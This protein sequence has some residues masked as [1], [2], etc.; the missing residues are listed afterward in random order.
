MKKRVG[1]IILLCILFFTTSVYASSNNTQFPKSSDFKGAV[2]DEVGVLNEE[3][4]E[5]INNT[6]SSLKS[7]TGGQIAVVILNSLNG[8]DAVSYSVG[9]FEQLKIGDKNK[10]NGA[11]II[12]AINDGEMRIETGYGTEGFIPDIYAN[13]I[14]QLMISYFRNTDYSN[15]IIEGYNQILSLYEEE[16]GIEV[17]NSRVPENQISN[18]SDDSY[19]IGEIF[20]III[21][22]ILIMYFFSGGNGKYNSSRRYRNYRGGYWG[23]GFGGGFGGFGGSSGGFGGFSGGGG[24]SGGGGASGRW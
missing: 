24:S 21:I 22:I 9:L 5:Y 3:D 17:E 19:T 20:R 18:S 16:Y 23:G 1:G 11:L 2:Y 10:D 13:R 7:K 15:G 14:V 4:I 6:N 8:Q 12:V